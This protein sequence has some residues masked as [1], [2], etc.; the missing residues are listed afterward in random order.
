MAG[1]QLEASTT[2]S[3]KLMK[4]WLIYKDGGE[5][6][7]LIMCSVAPFSETKIAGSIKVGF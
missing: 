4:K 1:G 3:Y 5:E 7:S 2:D 6:N